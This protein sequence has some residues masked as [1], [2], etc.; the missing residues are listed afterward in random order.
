MS[1]ER[2]AEMAG[3]ERAYVSGLERGR[4]NPTLLTLHRIASALGVP[5]HVLLGEAEGID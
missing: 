3:V 1:Q 4:R 2:L 5:L